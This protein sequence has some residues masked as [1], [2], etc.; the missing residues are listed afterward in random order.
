MAACWRELVQRLA[1]ERGHFTSSEKSVPTPLMNLNHHSSQSRKDLGKLSGSEIFAF[2]C[3]LSDLARCSPN[4][5][6]IS[7]E[8]V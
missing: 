6:T 3:S 7:F 5:R 8:R 1:I 2:N 4:L